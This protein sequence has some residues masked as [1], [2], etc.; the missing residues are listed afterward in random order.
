M[1]TRGY[2][3]YTNIDIDERERERERERPAN[4]VLTNIR[5]RQQLLY[6]KMFPVKYTPLVQFHYLVEV[7]AWG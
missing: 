2:K 7:L 3:Y 1:L 4:L 6:L 5:G